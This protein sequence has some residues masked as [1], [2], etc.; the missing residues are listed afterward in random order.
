MAETADKQ[1]SLVSLIISLSKLW[2]GEC[3]GIAAALPQPCHGK[4]IPWPP[5]QFSGTGMS[6]M[7]IHCMSLITSVPNSQELQE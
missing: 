5:Q 1:V 7:T 3:H 4:A 6:P 2:Q